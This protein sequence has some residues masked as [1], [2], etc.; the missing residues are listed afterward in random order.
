MALSL[1]TLRLSGYI[2]MQSANTLTFAISGTF[3]GLIA[4]FIFSFFY[5]RKPVKI[6]L[7]FVRSIHEIFWVMLLMTPL[8]LNDVSGILGIA[9]P[10]SAIFAKVYHEIIQE[11]NETVPM[12][13]HL[14][15]EQSQRFSL[16]SSLEFS[17]K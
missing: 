11:S 12:P 7:S 2:E 8:G 13:Y 5:N 6:V 14:I 9:I 1:L 16:P 3:F 17:Q 10:Y 4:G 15:L